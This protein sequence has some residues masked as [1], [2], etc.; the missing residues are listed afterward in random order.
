M[1]ATNVGSTV[2]PHV[3]PPIEVVLPVVHSGLWRPCRSLDRRDRHR[4]QRL[5]FTTEGKPRGFEYVVHI[6]LCKEHKAKNPA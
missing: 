6:R 4:S 5:L 1:C 3:I 2:T